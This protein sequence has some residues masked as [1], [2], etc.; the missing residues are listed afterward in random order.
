MSEKKGGSAIFVTA[1]GTG[2]GKTVVSAL[3]LGVLRDLGLRAGYQKWVSTGGA[4]PE[5]LLFCLDRNH[6]PF[7]PEKLDRVAPY[8]FALP[9]SP[10]LAAAREG[11]EIEP[12]RIR[13]SFA[14]A[15]AEHE[16]LVVEGVGGVLV[17]LRRDLLLA[18]FLT[19]LPLAVLVVACSGLGTINHTLLTLEALRRR[20]LAVLGLVFSDE[21]EG[22]APDD[23]LVSDNMQTIAGMGGVEV[24]GRL[25]RSRDYRR[26]QEAFHPI[27]VAIRR[28]LAVIAACR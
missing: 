20:K 24:F 7:D 8:R 10:H 21:R 6:L 23:P 4:I 17:P 26:L 3:L 15:L 28:K 25:P 22:M 19:D 13:E 16:V 27:G 5:D 18:D 2:V 11:R 9:A 1:T 12:A 14:L